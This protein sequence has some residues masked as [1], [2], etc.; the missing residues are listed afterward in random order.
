[1][2]DI[3]EPEKLFLLTVLVFENTALKGSEI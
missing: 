3:D 1:M 2:G